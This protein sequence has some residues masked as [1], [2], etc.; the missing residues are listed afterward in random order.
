LLALQ[1]QIV[2]VFLEPRAQRPDALI[3]PFKFELLDA[4][5]QHQPVRC[6]GRH[7]WRH[8]VAQPTGVEGRRRRDAVVVRMG[9]A[10]VDQR[11]FGAGGTDERGVEVPRSRRLAQHR[12][13]RQRPQRG[14]RQVVGFGDRV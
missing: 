13:Q 2:A 1:Q 11:Q 14:R 12:R 3:E 9:W 8:T 6:R 10:T 7:R 4:I 5:A